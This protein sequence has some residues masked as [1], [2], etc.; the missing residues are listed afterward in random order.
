MIR[1]T[2][3]A[4]GLAAALILILIGLWQPVEAEARWLALLWL[5]AP[6]AGLAVRL[7]LPTPPAALPRAV[8]NLGLVLLI[9]FA[10]LSLQLLR[11]QFV[12]SEAVVRHSVVA[13]DGGVTANVRP[14]LESQRVL[15][16]SMLDQ[17]GRVL[18]ESRAV[19]GTAQRVYPIADVYDLQA[20][21]H[22]LGFFSLRYGE[23]GLESVYSDYLTGRRGS[24]WQQLQQRAV[25]GQPEGNDLTLT[26]DAE[27]QARTAELLG[28]RTGSVVVLDP[29]S[30]AI[31]ALVSA[32]SFDLRSLTVDPTQPGS[33]E[34]ARIAAGWAEL[35][36]DGAQQPLLNR[37]TQGLYPPGSTFKALTALAVLEQE[38]LF[39][40]DQISCPEEYYPQDDAPPVVNARAELSALI[41]EPAT[42]ER[43]FAYSCNTA[44]AQY[45][46]RIGAPELARAAAQFG[47]MPPEQAESR[48]PLLRDLP[49]A[50][51]LLYV[52][53]NFLDQPRALADTGYG[54]GELLVTPLHMALIAAATANDGVLM[55]PYLVQQIVRPDGTV[56]AERNPTALA[57]VMSQETAAA[58]RSAMGAVAEYGFGSAISAEVPGVAVGGKSGTAEHAPGAVPHAWFIALAPLDA[59][60]YAV[61][62]MV[63]SGGE[64]SGV[65]AQL[66]GR[67]LAAA[68]A[69]EAGATP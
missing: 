2:A 42:L 55:E 61:A 45:A 1:R 15:R 43:V 9:G 46:L 34:A 57:R 51:A 7:L 25:G 32:P 63:E 35:N 62:V 16:G 24:L 33:S 58:L 56:Q 53:P 47:I 12:Q 5:A 40:A 4:T 29:R 13:A 50:A 54:Q 39:G 44:F 64:G 11:Q 20:F 66:A 52:T 21:A 65:A 23:S 36:A 48:G 18:V 30:G 37:A 49:A 19:A 17:R 14:V 6:T 38:G 59:P 10:M 68:L 22:V 8:A 67:V 26:I 3:A 31:R 60:R 69:V 41:G 27:L 28:G